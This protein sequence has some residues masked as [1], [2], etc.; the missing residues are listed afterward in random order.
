M[1]QNG[2][3]W[4]Y[5]KI[6]PRHLFRE[7]GL[8]ENKIAGGLRN[9]WYFPSVMT[10]NEQIV[11]GC[12]GTKGFTITALKAEAS[13]CRVCLC[14]FHFMKVENFVALA[15][16]CLSYQLEPKEIKS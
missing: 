15:H 6:P 7:T 2:I 9:V 8:V 3:E 1:L 16:V 13:L 10:E 5:H 4:K 12:S 11:P 14:L